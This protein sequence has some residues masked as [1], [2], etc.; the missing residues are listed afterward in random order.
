MNHKL[1]MNVI[2]RRTITHKVSDRWRSSRMVED[3]QYGL[4]TLA[5]KGCLEL[6]DRT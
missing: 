1:A 5:E 6:R 2:L 4:S 3:R